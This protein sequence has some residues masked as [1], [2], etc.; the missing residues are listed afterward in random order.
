MVDLLQL[1]PLLQ[2]PARQLSLGQRMRCDLTASLLHSPDI[3]YLDEPT[4]GLDIS[5]KEKIR[6]FIKRMNK[7]RNVTVLLTS[8]DLGDIEDLCTRLVMIDKGKVVFDGTLQDMKQRFGGERVIHLILQEEVPRALDV[9]A[10]ALMNIPHANILQP[11]SH[12]ISIH[13][14]SA[15]VTA[16]M[17]TTRLF[18]VLPVNDL[19]IEEPSIERVIRQLYEGHLQLTK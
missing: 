18:S 10:K 16:S 1:E 2:I 7:E 5:V 13:F 17:I 12:R 11:E 8:H 4:I 19:H 9:V 3:L 15:Q 6:Q 14:N